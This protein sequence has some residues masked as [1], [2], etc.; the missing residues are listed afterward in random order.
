M[1]TAE[2]RARQLKIKMQPNSHGHECLAD[3]TIVTAYY[4]LGELS[5]YSDQR[6]QTVESKLLQVE[7]RHGNLHELADAACFEVVEK[8]DCQLHIICGSRS[9]EHLHGKFSVLVQTAQPRS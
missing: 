9:C 4:K 5:K 2:V 1:K 3:M 8:I 7:R 6:I